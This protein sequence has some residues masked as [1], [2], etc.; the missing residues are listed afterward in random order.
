VNGMSAADY[1]AYVSL[2][3]FI[4]KKI[5]YLQAGFQNVSRSPSYVF[6]EQSSFYLDVPQKLNKE[7]ITHLFGSLE[8][9][10][11]KLAVS[12]NYYLVSNYAYYKDY[13]HVAQESALFNL[14]SFSIEKETRIKKN[15]NWRTWTVIQQKTGNVAINVPLLLT[16]NQVGYDGN[17]GFKNL[18]ISFGLESR[19]FTPYKAN[20]YSPLIGQF[21]LQD[22]ITIRLKAPEMGIYIHFRIKSFTAYLR[23]E[24]LNT[25]HITTGK[26]TNNNI[27][28][29]N[30]P[31]PGLQMRLAI[32]W[33]FVN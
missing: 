14:L 18:Q 30:Y 31:Y 3:R 8:Q 19:Y 2:K 20:G 12:G 28:L 10:Q 9:P 26:F 21:Y 17:L 7:N 24:N 13:F 5:G 6:N 16:R 22:S 25:L 15:W 1:D 33:G 11:R 32:Y 4:S 23:F 29:P 27:V